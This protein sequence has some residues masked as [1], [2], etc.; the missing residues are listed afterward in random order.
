MLISSLSRQYAL[1]LFTVPDN[2]ASTFWD[3]STLLILR[4]VGLRGAD[5]RGD[6]GVRLLENDMEK[7]WARAQLH[8]S[9][10]LLPM[11]V[12]A[13]CFPGGTTV[14]DLDKH[15]VGPTAANGAPRP[16]DP[17]RKAAEA[18]RLLSATCHAGSLLSSLQAKL[19]KQLADI[20]MGNDRVA[21]LEVIE[22]QF[23]KGHVDFYSIF[24]DFAPQLA[25]Y[26]AAIQDFSQHNAQRGAAGRREIG[27]QTTG[28]VKEAA[29]KYMHLSKDAAAALIAG[30]IGKSASTVRRMLSELFPGSAWVR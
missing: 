11:A 14:N 8:V 4:L 5:I 12:R 1:C 7:Y 27:E 25:G 24:E 3:W 28:K 10:V 13:K 9:D 19:R 21:A 23:L 26:L 22:E 2:R 17:R 18:V 15:L 20:P 30:E 16:S 6:E 29:P